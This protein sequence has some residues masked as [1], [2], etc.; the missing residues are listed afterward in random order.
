MQ[1][2]YRSPIVGD[3]LTPETA[4]RPAVHDV[5]GNFTCSVNDGAGLWLVADTD[6][7]THAAAL[8]IPGV[9]YLDLG[10]VALD[11]TLASVDKGNG[12]LTAMRSSLDAAHIPTD[13]LSG[14]HTVRDVLKRIHRRA[15][16]AGWLGA[17]DLD[18]G[19]DT[20]ISAIPA[21]RRQRMANKL[22][23]RSFDVGGLAGSMTVRQAI[24]LLAGQIR[25]TAADR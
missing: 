20:L 11:A 18:Q 19:L 22:T 10:D 8:A 4:F 1:R 7:A 5:T 13:D 17:D 2:I 12:K 24:R 23:A 16:I 15:L 21:A 3:G 14:V 9:T 6:A 25:A